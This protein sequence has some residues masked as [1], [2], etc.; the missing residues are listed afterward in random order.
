MLLNKQSS[1]KAMNND[2]WVKSKLQ[3]YRKI[4]YVKSMKRSCK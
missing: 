4:I 2:Y 1:G 3:N